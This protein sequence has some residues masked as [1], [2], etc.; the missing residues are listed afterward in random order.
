V[1]TPRELERALAMAER[2][3]PNVRAQLRRLLERNA[4]RR[5]TRGLRE[6]LRRGAP[7]LTRSEAE[8]VMLGLIRSAGLPDPAMNVVVQ[9]H[10]VDCYWREARLVVEVDGYAWHGSHRVFLRDRER[11]ATL[12]AAG[13]QVLRSAGSSSL[14]IA[15]ARSCSSPWPLRAKPTDSSDPP[16]SPAVT[17]L[18][19]RSRSPACSRP[20]SCR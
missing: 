8:E 4:T 20:W 17:P 14:L 15:T 13:V 3:D 9:G 5:G 16:A 10:E 18:A 11:D 19:S 1:A 7:T 2:N 6:L 12:A